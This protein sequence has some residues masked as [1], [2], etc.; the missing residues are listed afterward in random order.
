MIRPREGSEAGSIY[1]E[2]FEE[3]EGSMRCVRCTDGVWCLSCVMDKS[4]FADSD[5]VVMALLCVGEEFVLELFRM[6]NS[7][8]CWFVVLVLRWL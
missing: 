4:L 1:H 7:R 5:I 3:A 8:C 6:A 2:R